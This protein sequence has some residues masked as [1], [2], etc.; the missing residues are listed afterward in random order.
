MRHGMWNLAICAEIVDFRLIKHFQVISSTSQVMLNVYTNSILFRD[1]VWFEQPE[2]IY[3]A[4]Y[5]RFK[6]CLQGFM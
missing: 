6:D 1:M 3:G 2:Y 5:A 4:I